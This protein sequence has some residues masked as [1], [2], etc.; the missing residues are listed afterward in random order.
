MTAR[1]AGVQAAD[2]GA[3]SAMARGTPAQHT[4]YTRFLTPAASNAANVAMDSATA[5]L[6]R[7]RAPAATSI[8]LLWS[9]EEDGCFQGTRSKSNRR[10]TGGMLAA[11][12]RAENAIM[13]PTAGAGAHPL[14]APRT[15]LVAAHVARRPCSPEE[16][17]GGVSRLRPVQYFNK[18]ETPG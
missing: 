7:H 17:N 3:A 1:Q 5:A 11:C 16:K 2:S 13:Q 4:S 14:P 8:M 10:C 15:V 18:P 9:S 6:Q 12:S